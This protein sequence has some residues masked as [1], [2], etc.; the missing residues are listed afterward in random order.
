MAHE[1]AYNGSGLNPVEVHKFCPGTQTRSR[2]ELSCLPLGVTK[3]L[4]LGPVLVSQPAT[5]PFLQIAPRDPQ[6]RLRSMK[7][8]SRATPRE[9]IGDFIASYSS[10][11]R[12]PKEAHHM[13]DRD[14]I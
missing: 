1:E 13:L 11:S 12:H 10:M 7:P 5:E 8:Q 3:A 2:D 9:L 4:P 14:I 6:G